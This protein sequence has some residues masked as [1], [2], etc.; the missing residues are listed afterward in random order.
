MNK[1][2]D[3]LSSHNL[4]KMYFWST[5][6]GQ[7]WIFTVKTQ[8]G[9]KTHMIFNIMN[10]M[11]VFNSDW[12]STTT[13]EKYMGQPLQSKMKQKYILY[14]YI[15]C[16]CICIIYVSQSQWSDRRPINH[17]KAQAKGSPEQTQLLIKYSG[18]DSNVKTYILQVTPST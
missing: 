17:N 4:R 6:Q 18:L 12:A 10:R 2:T 9:Q 1:V 15:L 14:K 8:T 16:F 3:V 13:A 11:K 7:A 5:T